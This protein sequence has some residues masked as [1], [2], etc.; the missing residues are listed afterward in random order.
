MSEKK[1]GKKYRK[2]LE[3]VAAGSVSVDQAFETLAGFTGAQFDET[4]DVAVRLGVDPKVS[5]QNVRGAVVLPHGTGKV[6][7]LLVFAKGDKLKEAE[8]LGV[9][10]CGGEEYLQKIQQG[11]LDFDKIISTPD[12]MASVSKVAKILGPR[13]LMPSPKSGTVTFEIKKA[14][15]E[16]RRGKVNYKID[17]SGIVHAVIGKKSFGA[18]KLKENFKTLLDSIVRQKPASSKG[19]YLKSIAISATHSPSLLIESVRLTA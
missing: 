14:V 11:W 19:V 15:E 12:M 5:E 1:R 8:G 16:E 4:V 9:D 7:R 13:G 10:F 2:N 3:L 6:V 17:K 18:E